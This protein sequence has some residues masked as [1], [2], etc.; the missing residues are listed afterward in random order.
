MKIIE[1]LKKFGSKLANGLKKVGKFLKDSATTILKLFV[2]FGVGSVGGIAI[3]IAKQTVL[4]GMNP[5]LAA[6]N[7]MGIAVLTI[8]TNEIACQII[9]GWEED[10]KATISELKALNQQI[11]E[12]VKEEVI[13][14]RKAAER[15]K[16]TVIGGTEA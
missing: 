13:K 15:A 10:I 7:V 14:Q 3:N 8:V 6:F 9:D 16:Y 5:V 2:S 1:K 4:V 12:K 11:R